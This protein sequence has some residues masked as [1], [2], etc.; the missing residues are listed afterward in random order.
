MSVVTEH[1]QRR[2]IEFET[3]KH[4]R[5]FSSLEE[6]RALGIAA[7]EVVKTIVLE[8][9]NGPVLAAI[10]ASRRLDL[11]LARRLVGDRHARLATEEEIAR[12][13]PGFE[14]GAIPPLADLMGAPVL[15]DRE[16]EEHDTVVFAD[17]LQTES[18]ELRMAD[19]LA[20][21]ATRTAM[22]TTDEDE[23]RSTA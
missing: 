1:L 9:Q 7:D 2:G 18:V 14:L 20:I 4:A 19:L 16:L 6:A 13:F 12:V 8:T 17:G 21:D 10:P 22:L 11:H 3:R 23:R 15:I 5:A